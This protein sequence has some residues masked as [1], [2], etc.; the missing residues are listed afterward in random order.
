M[1]KNED[2]FDIGQM[3]KY[4]IKIDRND[5]GCPHLH[6]IDNNG[7]DVAIEL[8]NNKYIPETKSRL[9]DKE[10]KEFNKWIREIHLIIP[11]KILY[12]ELALLGWQ[13][14]TDNPDINIPKEQ[15]KIP[16]YTKIIY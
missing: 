16:D 15:I 2:I 10:C 4:I 12:W 1:R 11:I 9:L 14:V 3:D 6:I 8:F 5:I 7:F 13:T